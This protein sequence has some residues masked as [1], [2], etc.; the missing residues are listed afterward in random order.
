[1]KSEFIVE[2]YVPTSAHYLGE[3][4]FILSDLQLLI[5]ISCALPF[6]LVRVLYTF[7]STLQTSLRSNF[8]PIFGSLTLY[9]VMSVVM[10][11]LIVL[12]YTIVGLKTPVDLDDEYL[13]ENHVDEGKIRGS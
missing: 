12:I 1:M 3:F 11:F 2:E 4:K 6:L 7:L 13:L 8:S 10:E 9:V 5:G